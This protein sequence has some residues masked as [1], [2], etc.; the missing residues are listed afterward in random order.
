MTN[1]PGNARGIEHL[2]SDPSFRRPEKDFQYQRANRPNQDAPSH[3]E[4][5]SAYIP[6]FGKDFLAVDELHRVVNGHAV[7]VPPAVLHR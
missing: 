4:H 7:S 2:P 1:P 3:D 5:H 6:R